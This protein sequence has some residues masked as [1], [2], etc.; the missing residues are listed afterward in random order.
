MFRN[1]FFVLS[2]QYRPP[3]S[4]P[5][6]PGAH[7]NEQ[8]HERQTYPLAEKTGFSFPAAEFGKQFASRH[9]C[10]SLLIWGTL[11]NSS[12]LLS[13]KYDFFFSLLWGKLADYVSGSDCDVKHCGERDAACMDGPNVLQRLGL[14]SHEWKHK[15]PVVPALTRSSRRNAIYWFSCRF[16]KMLL[17]VWPAAYV[18]SQRAGLCFSVF[19]ATCS[20]GAPSYWFCCNFALNCPVS[21]RPFLPF[22]YFLIS[23]E[24]DEAH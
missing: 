19:L 17:E 2:F 11:A 6:P 10:R 9:L 5:F 7:Q 16:F 18:R 1:V 8:V 3:R 24:L 4:L 23:F 13:Q 21:S 12:C 14:P 15:I 22:I 20:C